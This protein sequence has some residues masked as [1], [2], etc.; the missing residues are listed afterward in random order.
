MRVAGAR[1]AK[2]G[3]AIGR[4]RNVLVGKRDEVFMLTGRL[5]KAKMREPIAIGCFPARTC[6]SDPMW[7]FDNN[8]PAPV[9]GKWSV[10]AGGFRTRKTAVSS[11]KGCTRRSGCRGDLPHPLLAFRDLVGQYLRTRRT[12]R[13]GAQKVT[14]TKARVHA[15]LNDASDQFFTTINSRRR[16]PPSSCCFGT[17]DWGTRW[18]F[19]I[20]TPRHRLRL[21]MDRDCRVM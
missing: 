1:R 9:R 7:R 20:D 4:R 12:K 8:C 16:H 2:S 14:N 11:V 6:G 13:F 21:A 15:S 18:S 19:R 10:A 3:G 17:T 5:Q